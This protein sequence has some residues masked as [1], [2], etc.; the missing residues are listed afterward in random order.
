MRKTSIEKIILFA[1]FLI[2]SLVVYS[3]KCS[4]DQPK[5]RKQKPW[6]KIVLSVDEI[7]ERKAGKA[8]VK[9]RTTYTKFYNKFGKLDTATYLV[10]K[11]FFDR[12][13]KKE[14]QIQYQSTGVVDLAWRYEYTSGLISRIV[15]KNSFDEPRADEQF[16]YDENGNEVQIREMNYKSKQFYKTFI[17]YNKN[18]LAVSRTT[19]DP[20]E[21]MVSKDTY[22]YKNGNLISIKSFDKLNRLFSE[23]FYEYD[24]LNRIT[25]QVKEMKLMPGKA[26]LEIKY[27]NGKITEIKDNDLVVKYEY[28]NGN[29]VKEH[30][31]IP[32]IGPQRRYD[33]FYNSKGLIKTKV[34]VSG[35][36]KPE[37]HVF[38]RYEYY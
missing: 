4:D 12:N 14:S 37:L 26:V 1:L 16:E 23:T 33:Y 19:F 25:K 30:H 36:G 21:S 28:A 29:I 15:A 9:V 17:K 18:Q 34:H 31:S 10:E 8:G 11:I 32:G 27:A 38:Y 20:N 7:E 6:D 2:S 3:C 22:E 35:I 13:G 24:S 5:V